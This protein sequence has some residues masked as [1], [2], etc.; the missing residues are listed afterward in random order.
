MIYFKMIEIILIGISLV[1]LIAICLINQIRLQADFNKWK[2]WYKRLEADHVIGKFTFNFLESK[3][4]ITK[5]EWDKFML[6]KL[7]TARKD[8]EALDQKLK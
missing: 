8:L 3:N 1:V 7:K 4:I 6:N 5:K 2:R